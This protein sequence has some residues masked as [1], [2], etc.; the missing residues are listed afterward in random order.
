MMSPSSAHRELR[1]AARLCLPLALMGSTF[2]TSSVAQ[3]ASAGSMQ[4]T[5]EQ[6]I[7]LALKQNH[8]IH[9]RN[10]SVEHMQSKKDQASSN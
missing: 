8:S 5:L 9:L 7:N 10:L 2:V 3:Q 4:L 6:A 1:A